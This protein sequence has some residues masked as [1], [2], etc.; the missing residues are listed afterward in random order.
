MFNCSHINRIHR[1]IAAIVVLFVL[2]LVVLGTSFTLFDSHLK[3][4]PIPQSMQDQR[5]ISEDG[6]I[7]PI[8]LVVIAAVGLPLGAYA[9]HTLAECEKKERE[10]QLN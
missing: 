4:E 8:F 6:N 3:T 7:L 9:V 5:P 10:G 1:S 2:G